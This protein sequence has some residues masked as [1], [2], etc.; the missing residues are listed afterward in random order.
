MDGFMNVAGCNTTDSPCLSQFMGTSGSQLP[1]IWS[2]ADTYAMSDRTF[3][4]YTSSSWVAHMEFGSAT[5][6]SWHGN[7]PHPSA[8]HAPGPGWGCN[9]FNDAPW[10]LAGGSTE[11]LPSCVPDAS[12]AGPY[13][14]TDATYTPTIMDRLDGA[15]LSWRIYVNSVNSAWSICATFW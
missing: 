4:P 11:L 15:G 2:L 13:R 14:P 5:R 7:N 8:T 9:S 1:N 10:D 12:G 6:E 3:E